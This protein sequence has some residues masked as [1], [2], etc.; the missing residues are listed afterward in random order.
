MNKFFDDFWKIY[1]RRTAKKAAIKE[2][3]KAIK[4][5]ATPMEIIDGTKRYSEYVLSNDTELRYIKHASTF[6]HQ[7]CWEDEYVINGDK[8]Q[9]VSR[10]ESLWI[11]R[12]KCWKGG[13]GIWYDA[14]GPKPGEPYCECPPKYLLKHVA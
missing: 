10:E 7:G 13:S 9:E 2:F 1:P 6:L 4:E 14:W 5:G 8:K 12:V 3:I 11:G